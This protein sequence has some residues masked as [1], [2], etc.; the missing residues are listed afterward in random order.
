MSSNMPTRLLTKYGAVYKENEQ[1]T[2]A[3]EATP[4]TRS[5]ALYSK[6]K[7]NSPTKPLGA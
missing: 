7:R 1:D 2:G 5:A 3:D 4:C 6:A